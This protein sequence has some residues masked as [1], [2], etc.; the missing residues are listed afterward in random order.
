MRHTTS[1]AAQDSDYW[2]GAG[3][4]P[5]EEIKEPSIDMQEK[6]PK[7]KDQ[8]SSQYQLEKKLYVF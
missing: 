1:D 3:N 6:R 5:G 8:I 7:N 4:K 2:E